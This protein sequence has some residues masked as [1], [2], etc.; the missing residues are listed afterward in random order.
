M[1][2]HGV[3]DTSSSSKITPDKKQDASCDSPVGAKNTRGCLLSLAVIDKLRNQKDFNFVDV[4]SPSEFDRYRIAGS[5]NIPLHLVKTKVFLKS[6][7]F[8]LVNEGRNTTDIEKACGEL[9]QAGFTR[10]SV[11]EGGLFG[12]YVSKRELQGDPV[13]QARLNLMSAGELFEARAEHTMS[14]WAVIDVSTPGKYK[15]MHTWLPAKI[16]T[17]PLKA[18]GNPIA[19]ISSIILSQHKRSPKI[20]L[21]LVADDNDAYEQI[22]S[23]LKK[24]GIVPSLL[25]LDGGL[26]GYREYVTRQ[27]ALWEQQKQPRRYEACRG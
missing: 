9:K 1:R 18:K 25:H 7:P 22:D 13:A 8:V 23:R 5:I 20:K 4:R 3:L 19:K 21:L 2:A 11:L 27:V 10:V 17:I 6:Q 26:K 16:I 12:W 15:D 24:S 14:G